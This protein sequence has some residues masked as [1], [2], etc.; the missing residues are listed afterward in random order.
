[1]ELASMYV[2]EKLWEKHSA[3]IVTDLQDML[4]SRPSEISRRAFEIDGHQTNEAS[5][6]TLQD[7]GGVRVP[8]KQDPSPETPILQYYERSDV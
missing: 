7:F 8:L 5:I 6:L 1:M 4:H 3:R 2:V